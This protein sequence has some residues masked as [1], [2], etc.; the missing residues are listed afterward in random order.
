MYKIKK[1]KIGI[2]QK[3]IVNKF[4]KKGILLLKHI[5][6]RNRGNIKNTNKIKILRLKI[7]IQIVIRNKNK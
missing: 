2:S 3:I 7:Q 1:I 5:E 6:K 4:I